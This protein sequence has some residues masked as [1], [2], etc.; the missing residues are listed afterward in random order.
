MDEGDAIEYFD[1]NI[2][3]AYV[4]EITPFIFTK[5]NLQDINNL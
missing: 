3:G 2:M 1:F 5:M 4:G